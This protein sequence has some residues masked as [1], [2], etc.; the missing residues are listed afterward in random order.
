MRL[1]TCWFAVAAVISPALAS[2]PRTVVKSE[3]AGISTVRAFFTAFDARDETAMRRL[4]ASTATITHD[5][6]V[7]TDVPTMMRIISGTAEWPPRTRELSN[8]TIA[9]LAGGDEVVTFINKVRFTPARRQPSESKYNETWVL[10]KE[11]TGMRAIRVHYSL[12]T[13]EKHSENV[14]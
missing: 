4:L 14:Q 7:T 3:N 9:K 11:R 12:V 2:P 10:E 1:L 13:Q 8:F 5:N 6:G